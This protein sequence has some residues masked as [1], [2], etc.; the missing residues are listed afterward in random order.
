MTPIGHSPPGDPVASGQSLSFLGPGFLWTGQSRGSCNVGVPWSVLSS[1]VSSDPGK[2]RRKR[3]VRGPKHRAWTRRTDP[4][5]TLR[6]VPREQSE[7]IMG[8]G[9]CKQIPNRMPCGIQQL[10]AGQCCMPRGPAAPKDLQGHLPAQNSKQT[11]QS[12]K[13]N[14]PNVSR[15]ARSRP[16]AGAVPAQT[17]K[18]SLPRRKVS[19]P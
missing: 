1:S 17:G 19:Q 11:P 16:L 15:K 4:T 10:T 18:G 13:K 14:W 3:G 7:P 12:T 9:A 5:R 8:S 2:A 6:P